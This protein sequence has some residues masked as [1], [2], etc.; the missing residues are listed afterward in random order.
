MSELIA[1]GGRSIELGN[2]DKVLFPE[3]GIT[4]R[5]LAAYYRDIGEVM[6]PHVRGR[7]VTMQRFPDGVDGGGFFQKETPDHF[8]GWITRAT[9]PKESGEVT[10]VLIDRPATLVYLADQGCITPHVS[11]STMDDWDRPD[12]MVFDLDPPDGAEVGAVRAAARSVRSLLDELGFVSRIMTTGSKGY[13]VVVPLDRMAVF[14]VV[15]DVARRCAAILTARHPAELTVEHRID[16]RAGRVFVDYLRNGYGQ[17]TVAPYAVRP[18]SGAPI[19]TPID[20]DEL[21]RVEPGTYTL[22]NIRR[23]L[24]QKDDPWTSDGMAPQSLGAVSSQLTDMEE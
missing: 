22:D 14:D 13:H 6:L 3:P 15:R 16:R 10:H 1:A 5:D 4:K 19:A 24:G 17:T 23:R 9:L 18:K 2:P 12:R 20:W 7:A 11:L 8:P 21:S